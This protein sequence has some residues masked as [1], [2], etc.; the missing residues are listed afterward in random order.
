MKVEIIILI[1]IAI[2]GLIFFIN[3]YI[4]NKNNFSNK[5]L[6]MEPKNN[7]EDEEGE[8]NNKIKVILCSAKWCGHCKHFMPTW[9]KLNELFGSQFNFIL[10]DAD[11]D[12]EKIKKY[13]VNGFPTMII[14]KENQSINTFVGGRP[15]EELSDYFNSLL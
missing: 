9:E 4:I 6:Y 13:K 15:I 2:F 7:E 11:M 12:K 8:Y 10:L 5:E 3:K 14:E 1:A